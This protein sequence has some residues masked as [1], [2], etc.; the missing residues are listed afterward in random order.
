[1]L[2]NVRAASE[3]ARAHGIPLFL[4][5]CRYAE[6]CYFVREP[7]YGH[8]E[9]REIAAELFALADGCTMSA[10]KDG[11]GDIG[12]FLALRHPR[13]YERCR[14]KLRLVE[15]EGPLRH[16]IARVAPLAGRL[17]A[18]AVSSQDPRVPMRAGT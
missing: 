8:K 16:V 4:D 15:E 7:G 13:L 12:G 17:E 1:M 2:A 14:E 18:T 3:L 5:A 6:N 10:K 9:P 11:I